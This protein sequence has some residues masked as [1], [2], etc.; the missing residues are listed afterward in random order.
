MEKLI[1]RI[2]FIAI[3]WIWA[4]V[5]SFPWSN[6]WIN[7]PFS[8][9][10]YKLGLDLSWWVELDYK[11]DLEEA[12]KAEDYDANKE[13]EIID[14]LKSIVDKRIE[15]LNIND[16][17]ITTASYAWEKHII[18]QI[19]LKWET[20]EENNININRAKEAIWKVVKIEF[21]ELRWEIKQ[22]D[23]KV[24]ENL[25]D[26]F[27][28]DLKASTY[29]FFVT[30]YKYKDSYEKVDIWTL[31]LSL[32]DFREN[33]LADIPEKWIYNDKIEFQT[34]TISWTNIGVNN[35]SWFL[36]LDIKDKTD[37]NIVFDYWFVSGLPSEWKS[38]KDSKWRILND[39]Y[40]IKSAVVSDQTSFEPM[41]E[42]S[43]NND[44]AEIFWELTKRLVGQPIAIFVWWELLTAPNVNDAIL[45][46]RAVITGRYTYPEAK[47]LSTDINTWVIPAPIYL[48]S[49]RTI[50]SKLWLNSL[51]NL[52]TAWVS[53]FIIIF[54][55]LIYIYRFSWLA[56]SIALFIYTLLVLSIV[57]AL[58]LVLTLASVAGLILSIWI[59]IDANILI[60]ERVRDEIRRW[61]PILK[62]IEVWFD[63]SW[64]AIWDSNITWLII[65]FILFIFWVNMIKGFGIM[66]WIWIIVSL[67]SAMYISR[68]LIIAF[69]KK[70]TSKKSFI[71]IK[72]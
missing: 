1:Y 50:D 25:A 63:K 38:A 55:F 47:K 61:I 27:L 69:A 43:F 42:L 6:Y 15:S 7:I 24:R 46:W 45:S 11:V 52:I 23:Y 21:K 34:K 19:P 48:T 54:L 28:N 56:A 72:K 16:S 32:D 20:R 2:I 41:V 14:S 17:V 53:W 30:A 40:F 66:L 29:N 9:S 37:S 68:V 33:I 59:A 49:E 18:V 35:D 70:I 51:E 64:S 12:R 65:S 71:G 60:F 13:K 4:F 5:Y 58:W 31:E 44:W 8:W 3:L 10:N 62:S 57:K 67:F 36:I 39:K 22:E 26:K